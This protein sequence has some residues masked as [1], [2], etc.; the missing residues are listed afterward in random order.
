MP[1]L[2]LL[3]L[4]VVIVPIVIWAGALRDHRRAARTGGLQGAVPLAVR[5]WAWQKVVGWIGGAIALLVLFGVVIW[6]ATGHRLVE[7]TPRCADILRKHPELA[8]K[9]K[10]RDEGREQDRR[11]AKIKCV[12]DRNWDTT[13]AS[14]KLWLSV[15]GRKVPSV[16]VDPGVKPLPAANKQPR[17]PAADADA[18]GTLDAPPPPMPSPESERSS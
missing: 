5:L 17:Q 4:L 2:I 3:V 12:D 10:T 7:P 6:L 9:P 18:T 1:L 15:T 16:A 13:V 8:N 11:D 14:Y